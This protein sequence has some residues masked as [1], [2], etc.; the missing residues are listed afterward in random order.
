MKM[1]TD[2]LKGEQQRRLEARKNYIEQ[3]LKPLDDLNSLSEGSIDCS[4]LFLFDVRFVDFSAQLKSLCQDLQK[5]LETHEAN[6]YDLE[7][8]IRKQ[9]YDVRCSSS[10]R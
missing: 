8:K 1:A 7:F 9:D 4:T 6:R 3:R 10:K 5:Q 2:N